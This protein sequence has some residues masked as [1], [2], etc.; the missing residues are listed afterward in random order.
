MKSQ[1]HLLILCFVFLFN[2]LMSKDLTAS[3]FNV[4]LDETYLID[5]CI[6]HDTYFDLFGW[7]WWQSEDKEE[8]NPFRAS[9][10]VD[11]ESKLRARLVGQDHAIKLTVSALD[12]YAQGLHDRNAP[13]ASLLF[14]GPTGVGKTQ[15]AKELARI[16]LGSEQ[17]LLRLN[18]S[19]YSD[20]GSVY[21]LIGTPPGYV[22]HES[23]G[24]FTEALKRNPYAIVLLD[25]VEKAHPFV[26]KTFLQL[27]EEGFISDSK[28]KLVDC[29]NCLFI[30][31][32]NLAGQRILTMHDLGHTDREILET[33]QPTLMNELSPELYNRLEPVIFR[34]LKENILDNLI[35][36]MLLQATD[37][38]N[39]KKKIHVE[40]DASVIQFLKKKANY[41]LGARPIKQLIK[42]T[43]MT[44]ITEALR[45]KYIK[46][47]ESVKI[48]YSDSYF[49][50][51]NLEQPEPFIWKWVD[52][53]HDGVQPPFKLTQLLDLSQKLQQRILGQPYA[54]ETTVAALMR[55]AAGLGS[56]TSPIGTF[57]YVGPTGVGKTQLAKELAAELLGSE[58]HLIRLDMS[59][60]SE[61]HSTSRL[62]GS[63]PGYVNHDEGGQLTEAL[64]QHPY[65][66]VL[67][68]EIEKAHP[69]VLKTFLQV[70]DE[71][72]LSDAQGTVID[73]R[74]VIFILTTNLASKKILN[75]H[76]E[77]YFEEEI[78]QRIQQDITKFL[79]PEL[80]NRLEVAPFMGLGK[81]QLEQL[82]RNM[83]K[84]VQKELYLKKK[85]QISFD[86]SIIDFLQVN[87]FD[88]ELGARPL[89]RL[90]QQT[91]VTSIAKAILDGRI[92]VDDS[93]HISYAQDRVVIEKKEEEEEI[94]PIILH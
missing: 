52:E 34:G 70:F 38:L 11:L 80:Y 78:I 69:N 47:G 46:E 43:V 32:T 22:N 87:G 71:G 31:T 62:I 72:R 41:L 20:Y 77:G 12:R 21:R 74:N 14:V 42:Q 18:M 66:I 51:W 19:E 92:G 85:I 37:E 45:D 48:T 64:K 53:E 57:L 63:P 56:S 36:N 73:C 40:F 27:F 7:P 1:K 28:G 91:I 39:E 75:L 68:D 65:A 93:I 33:I 94:I 50:I 90:I 67:L 6:P 61:A 30:L 35:H 44:A 8:K 84:D 13:I 26:L 82:I 54:I 2:S 60:Y 29:R 59:E 86:S 55:Y 17:Q 79:S 9:Q 5:E 23:G 83:L 24:Q 49:R 15:L 10:L 88:Y 25:E 89:K 81:E 16:L 76:A 58:S 4:T 3:G